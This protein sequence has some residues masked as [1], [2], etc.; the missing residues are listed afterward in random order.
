A[1]AIVVSEETGKVSTALGSK[2]S[3]DLTLE[4]L[5]RQMDES[6]G[7]RKYAAHPDKRRRSIW[8][9]LASDPVRKAAALVLGFGM[10]YV[11]DKRI[12][13]DRAFELQV[14]VV[15]PGEHGSSGNRL[16]LSLPPDRAE[17]TGILDPSGN[18][19]QQVT[20]SVN[21]PRG[22]VDK[23]PPTLEIPVSLATG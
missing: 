5:E 16:L 22:I 11:L 20:L 21:G 3:F 4:Q 6:L 18:A 9:S 17:V 8:T 23:L 15:V 14:Q 12:K 19:V 1:L 13:E 10:Y 7:N 2:L